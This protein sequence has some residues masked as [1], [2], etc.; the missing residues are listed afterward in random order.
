MGRAGRSYYALTGVGIALAVTEL[1]WQRVALARSVV[2]L[3]LLAAA[4]AAVG[5]MVAAAIFTALI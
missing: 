4:V 2:T 3:V 5:L 1:F